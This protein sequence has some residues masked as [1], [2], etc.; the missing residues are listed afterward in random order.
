MKDDLQ[1]H[2]KY[3]ISEWSNFSKKAKKECLSCDHYYPLFFTL[4]HRW[5]KNNFCLHWED[6]YHDV[7][8]TYAGCQRLEM[9]RKRE[10]PCYL[11]RDRSHKEHP[12]NNLRKNKDYY[13]MTDLGF[14][15]VP[16]RKIPVS[17][18]KSGG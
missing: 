15:P 18:R 8:D 12:F 3:I 2:R 16:K 4:F 6:I 11:S 13:D 5:V 10:Y 7:I 17:I 9:L 1:G 14:K